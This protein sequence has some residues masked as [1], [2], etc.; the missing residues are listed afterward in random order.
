MLTSHVSF[1]MKH[2]PKVLTQRLTSGGSSGGLHP[3]NVANKWLLL[4]S[5]SS[6]LQPPLL[7]AL[8]P[9]AGVQAF[10]SAVPL[11]GNPHP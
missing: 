8:G 2:Y 1:V 7:A 10:P 6:V 4:Q 11:L 5:L 9:Q 3:G